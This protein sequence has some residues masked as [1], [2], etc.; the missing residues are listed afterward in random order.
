MNISLFGTETYTYKASELA[1]SIGFATP[2]DMGPCRVNRSDFSG[3]KQLQVSG[4]SILSTFCRPSGRVARGGN[5][6]G[7]QVGWCKAGWC[8]HQL[9][10]P[11]CVII[12]PIL[13]LCPI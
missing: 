6:I 11:D 7:G 1:G 4:V 3:L 10:M 9:L 12:I 5:S 13:S 2:L 8:K